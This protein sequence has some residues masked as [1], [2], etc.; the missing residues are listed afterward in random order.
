MNIVSIIIAILVFSF[1]VITHEL[2]HFLFAKRAGIGVTEFSVGMGPRIFSTVK[3]ETRYSVKA[4][5]FGGSCMMVGEDEADPAP[6]AFNNKTVGERILTVV[7]GPLFNILC[8]F[9][10]SVFL[11]M[12]AGVNTPKVYS[13]NAGLGAEA[14]G[15]QVG[16]IIRSINGHRITTGGDIVLMQISDPLD[17]SDVTVEYERNG[18]R[19][20]VTYDPHYE[21]YRIGISY[22][23]GAGSAEIGELA[24]GSPAAAAGLKAGDVITAVDG[25]ATAT[26]EALM[27]YFAQNPPDGSEI[28]VTY[29]R[30]G[31]SYEAKI[32][33]AFY[34]ASVLG[35]DAAYY[36]EKAGIGGTL[37]GAFRQAVYY[38]KLTFVS[39]KMLFTGSAGLS[40]MSGPVGIVSMIS[41]T[42]E[43]SASSGI[44]DV[45]LNILNLS[46]LLSVNLGIMNLLPLPALDGGRLIF[47][48]VEGLRG[49]PVPPDKEGMVHMAGFALLM[50]LM[51]VVMFN[52]IRRI[53]GF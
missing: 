10:L 28:T 16:D 39:L 3:G 30:D 31:S 26:G 38:V 15:I 43:E 29:E 9:I 34:E 46:I 18:E 23:S 21:V 47:L 49:K 5:P 45:V 4:I 33:P 44:L 22:N 32:T 2:G 35:F 25:T 41:D 24:E 42:V 7:G 6:N 8:A 13:V 51:V 17:G 50:L 36:R 14:A 1:L 11:I 53:V 27:Q 19:N 12:G 48:I 40:D 52:D 37:I 20:T